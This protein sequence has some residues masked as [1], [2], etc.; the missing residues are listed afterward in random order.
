MKAAAIQFASTPNAPELNRHKAADLINEA[1]DNGARLLVLPEFW[2]AGF[3][4]QQ[5]LSHAETMRDATVTL[6]RQLAKQRRVFIIGGSRA[7]KRDGRLY[8]TVVA[9]DEGGEIAA[10]Y[11]KVHLPPQDEENIFSPGDEW[12]LTECAGLRL[13]FL[14]C[15][16][17]YFPEFARNLALRGAQ[18][19]ALPVLFAERV[20]EARL[21]ARARAL[22]NGCFVI[23]ANQAQDMAA[24]QSLIISPD[25]CILAEAGAGETVL[26]GELDINSL[27]DLRRE[28]NT[29]NQRRNILDEIDN[30]QL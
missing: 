16:D 1:A 26:M 3:E 27:T 6:L 20:A 18:L 5:V 4:P 13:G 8:N 11:R 29:M 2:P 19:L 23:M 24:G 10:K 28:R 30:S 9:I 12:T 22:E 21:L 15:Y 25:G 17:I 14:N 7:E